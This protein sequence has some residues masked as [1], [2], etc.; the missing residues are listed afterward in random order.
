[1][2]LTHVGYPLLYE[3]NGIKMDPRFSQMRGCLDNEK[4]RKK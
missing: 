1:M 4:E 2:H 3:K